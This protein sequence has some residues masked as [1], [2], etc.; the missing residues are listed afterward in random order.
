MNDSSRQPG[1]SPADSD[2]KRR[3]HEADKLGDMRGDTQRGGRLPSD[4]VDTGDA[5]RP[6]DGD[7]KSGI[8]SRSFNL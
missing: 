5:P 3:E 2:A 8:P 7:A 6:A 4:E 1:G